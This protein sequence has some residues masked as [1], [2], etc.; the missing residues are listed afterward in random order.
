MGLDRDT[1]ISIIVAFSVVIVTVIPFI[2]SIIVAS[3]LVLAFRHP[4]YLFTGGE[5]VANAV[6]DLCPLTPHHSPSK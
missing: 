1:L 5:V 6:S 2:I 4:S 3:L